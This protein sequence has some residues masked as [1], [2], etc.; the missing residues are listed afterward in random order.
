MP[1][2]F[3]E[4]TRPDPIPQLIAL[5]M[6]AEREFHEAEQH[7]RTLDPEAGRFLSLDSAS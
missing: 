7:H 3:E 5:G 2:L 6:A 1:D 4:V